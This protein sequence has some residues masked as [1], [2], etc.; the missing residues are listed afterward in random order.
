V[1]TA[2]DRAASGIRALIV[3]GEYEP[4]NRLPSERELAQHL[5]L[6][7][8]ALRE[9]IRRLRSGGVLESRRGSGT[10]VS[11]IDPHAVYDIRTR[12]EPLAAEWA[13]LRRTEREAGEMRR[14]VDL[15]SDKIDDPDTFNLS[16]AKFHDIVA[17]SSRSPVLIG[18]LDRLG[19]LALLTRTA[20]VND[21]RLRVTSLTDVE[22]VC[23]AIER[24]HPKR[25]ANAMERHILNVRADYLSVQSQSQSPR[26]RKAV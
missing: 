22:R 13:A 26:A 5:G 4:G 15:M 3:A 14:I 1:D 16:D 12:L 23:A 20:I 10:Y 25:A 19:E 24:K 2:A 21:K 6:S 9:G 11:Q 7:R 18:T 17:Q 8:P